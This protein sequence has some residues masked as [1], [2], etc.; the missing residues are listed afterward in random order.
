MKIIQ[1]QL[2]TVLFALLALFPNAILA[3]DE[4]I[5]WSGSRNHYFKYVEQES[6]RFGKNDHPAELNESE[7]T[8][9]LKT[10]TFRDDTFLE[11]EVINSVFSASQIKLIAEQVSKGLK[12]A[13]PEQDIV[14]AIGG[15][16]KK[17]LLLTERT[18]IAGRIFYKENKLNII[19]G[20]Y[21]LVRNDSVEKL[22][23]P[24]DKGA[25]IYSFNFG[26]R[27]KKSNQFKAD[28]TGIPGVEQKNVKG[29]LRPDWLVID[30]ELAA[31]TYITN[32]TKKEK[33]PITDA[34]KELRRQSELLA[35]QRR[36][37][38]AEMA[39]LRK[40]VQNNS[41]GSGASAKSIEERIATLDQLLDKKLITQ[42][43]YD[44]KR[45]EILSD[46]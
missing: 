2:F 33:G 4:D 25:I 38:R 21:D 31:N 17:L 9:A 26:K 12:K 23:D 7:I 36:E 45:K 43:E 27:S 16:S 24:S 14:F 32:K 10:L 5:I 11:G 37:M 1:N 40:E 19:I 41:G 35:K 42:E 28:I 20:E 13:K 30:V 3:A 39:R 8:K 15:K 22:I 34:D 18:F 46:I 6:S 44:N 29:K